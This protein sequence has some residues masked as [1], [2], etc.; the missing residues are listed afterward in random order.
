MG[1][2]R[3]ATQVRVHQD[4]EGGLEVDASSE[5]GPGRGGTAARALDVQ[6]SVKDVGGHAVASSV[7]SSMM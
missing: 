7:H 3:E 2:F 1:S 4:P 6:G 5:Q